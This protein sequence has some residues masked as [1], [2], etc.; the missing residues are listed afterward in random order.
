MLNLFYQYRIQ[1]NKQE[2]HIMKDMYG[3]IGKRVIINN[4]KKIE[5]NF[6]RRKIFVCIVEDK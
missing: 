1:S 4:K 6:R 2:V 3:Y 5:K